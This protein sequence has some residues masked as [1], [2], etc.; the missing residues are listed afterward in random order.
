MVRT[1]GLEPP[2]LAALVPQTS[3]STIPPRPQNVKEPSYLICF[4]L[5]FQGLAARQMIIKMINTV[6]GSDQ[7]LDVIE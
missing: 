5:K 3:V 6:I 4:A 7:R 1:R 2:R